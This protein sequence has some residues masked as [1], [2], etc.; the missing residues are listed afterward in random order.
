M[1]TFTLGYPRLITEKEKR[2][3]GRKYEYCSV[4]RK[5]REVIKTDDE[6]LCKTCGVKSKRLNTI[7][8]LIK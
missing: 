4:C 2:K 3:A 7:K 8:L 5:V 1:P 6:M